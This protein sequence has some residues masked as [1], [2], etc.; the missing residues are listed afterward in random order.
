MNRLLRWLLRGVL[1]AAGL[2]AAALGVAWLLVA[3]SLPRYAGEVEAEG[4]A[5]PV[6]VIRDANAVPHIRAATDRDMWF[7]LGLVHA[8]DRLWQMEVS[9]RAAQGRLSALFG[10]RTLPLDRLVRT[11][12]LYG[13][14]RRAVADQTPAA[15]VALEAYAAGVNA[16]VRHVDARS[17][18]RGAPE[19]FLFGDG[20]EPWT[21]A[22]SLGILKVMALRLSGAARAEVRRALFQLA[23]PPER[24]ADILPDY[25]VPGQLTVPRYAALFPGS[26]FAGAVAPAPDPLLE[27]LGP[28]SDPAMAGASNAWAVDASRSSSRAPLL[29]NDPHLW[30]SAPSVW[31]LADI[32]GDRTRG[33]GGTLPGVPAIVIGHNGRLGWGLA[34]AQLDD[35]DIFIERVNPANPEEY[36]APEGW[37]PFERRRLRIEVAGEEPRVETF[38]TTRHGPVLAPEMFGVGQVTPEGHVAALAWTGLAEPDRGYSTLHGLLA[39]GSVAEGIEALEDTVAPAQVVTL[40]DGRGIGLAIAGQAPLRDPANPVRGRLPAP[41]W[42]ALN[43]WQGWLPRER[44]PGIV[45]PPEGAVATANHRLTDASWPDNLGHDWDAPYRILRIEKELSGRLFH[46]RD[47]FIALQAD[48]VSEMA[49]SVLPLVARDLW[50]REGAAAGSVPGLRGEALKLLAE[51]NGEMDQHAPEPLIFSEWMV[52]LTSRLAADELG[53]LLREVRG[54]QPLFIERVFRNI[55]GAEVWCDVDKTPERETCDRI[56]A[57]ALDDALGAL[58]RRHGLPIAGWRWGAEHR[59]VHRHMPLGFARAAGLLVNIEQETSGGD[60]TLMRGLSTGHGDRPFENVHASGLRVVYDFA[61]L[62][63]SVMMISTG[64]SGHPFSRWYDH[65]SE[66]WA[67]G[68]V[69]PMS[70]NDEE[71]RSGAVGVMRIVPR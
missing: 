67:R 58:E 30:L 71:A 10:A 52:Q 63:R 65:L 41:G 32:R 49:R 1:A 11:L 50:W 55:D 24:V 28:A 48:T 26:R 46:S 6:E 18:G 23:L 25:P 21:P 12:D 37:L 4:L 33:I 14:A 51:W 36:L 60:H 27:A 35:Q 62:N 61:D 64:Q 54:P 45:A 20:F 39:A 42:T 16:W 70:M 59:A 40:A 2:A 69:I 53:A 7:A 44:M 8:Q 15:Q 13:L 57:E 29:A 68:D 43:D 66:P 17:L 5:A 47:S 22:D 31:Y 9:R 19:F 34:T 56:A 3:G 38:R